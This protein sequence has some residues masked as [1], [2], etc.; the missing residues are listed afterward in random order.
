M[1]STQASRGVAARASDVWRKEN[2]ESFGCE[3]RDFREIG[4]GNSAKLG[5]KG[6]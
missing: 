5:K 6:F 1:E 2:R 3:D 4:E